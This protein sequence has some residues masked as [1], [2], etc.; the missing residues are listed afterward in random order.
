MEWKLEAEGFLIS[1]FIELEGWRAAPA[2]QFK[3]RRIVQL[4]TE[5]FMGLFVGWQRCPS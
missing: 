1:Q 2:L 3:G 4:F 5:L